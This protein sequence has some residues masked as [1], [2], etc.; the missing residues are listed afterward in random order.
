MKGEIMKM[1]FLLIIFVSLWFLFFLEIND[2]SKKE[3]FPNVADLKE[4]NGIIH[5]PT[6]G[7]Y[8]KEKSFSQGM[9][10]MPGQSATG[11]M[12]I[13]IGKGE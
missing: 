10:L 5:H 2:L 13:E 9:T 12:V 11:E 7:E 3:K 4:S 6:Y 1:I 8:P